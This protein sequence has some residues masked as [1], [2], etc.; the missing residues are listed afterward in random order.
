MTAQNNNS[1]KTMPAQI[2]RDGSISV[3]VWKKVHKKTDTSDTTIFYSIDMKR[4]YKSGDIWKST[5]SINGRD[6]LRVSNLYAQ[7]NNW[8]IQQQYSVPTQPE[9][10]ANE[11]GQ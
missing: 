3:R 7:A 5:N 4:G 11:S 1:Q 8:I 2:F 9:T 6:A 10:L